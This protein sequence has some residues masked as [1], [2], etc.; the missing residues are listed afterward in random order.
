MELN[1]EKYEEKK[2]KEEIVIVDPTKLSHINKTKMLNVCFTFIIIRK[3]CY[4]ILYF[5]F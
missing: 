1:L 4:L 3:L 2:E 5:N